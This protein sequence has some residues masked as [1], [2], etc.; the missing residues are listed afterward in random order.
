MIKQSTEDREKFSFQQVPVKEIETQ[1]SDLDPTKSLTVG[2]ILVKILTEH[3]D[4][5]APMLH[6]YINKRVN[7]SNFPNEVKKGDII[8]FLRMEKPCKRKYRAI[9]VLPAMSKIYE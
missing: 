4:V 5:F 3:S 9:T 1:L 2:S 7:T 6:F 8:P